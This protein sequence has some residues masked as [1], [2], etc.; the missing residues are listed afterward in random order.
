M[1]G[2]TGAE[3][4]PLFQVKKSRERLAGDSSPPQGAVDPIAD[5]A[6]PVAQ[7]TGDVSGYLPIGYDGLCQR[8][9][10]RQDLCPMLVE[11]RTFARTEDD[12]RHGYRI[13][14]VFKKEGQVGRF[15]VA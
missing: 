2:D 10:I 11:L 13:S 9:L 5:L 6:L 12:Q 8:S 7:E 4:P 15:D 3:G 14:L 1:A